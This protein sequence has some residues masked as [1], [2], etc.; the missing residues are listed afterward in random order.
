[1]NIW[2][3]YKAYIISSLIVVGVY[4]FLYAIQY[5]KIMNLKYFLLLIPTSFILVASLAIP[6]H[7]LINYPKKNEQ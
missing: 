5:G 1:M 7:I 4:P 3:K 6:L 2:K